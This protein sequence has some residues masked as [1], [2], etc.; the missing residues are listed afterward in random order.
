MASH[1]SI[2]ALEIP[3]TEKPG[4]LQSLGLQRARH[5]WATEHAKCNVT[6]CK[7]LFLCLYWQSVVSVFTVLE[8]LTYYFFKY[9]FS[10]TQNFFIRLQ[11]FHLLWFCVLGTI[12]QIFAKLTSSNCYALSI[13]FI[14]LKSS[15]PAILSQISFFSITFLPYYFLHSINYLYISHTHLFIYHPYFP[16]I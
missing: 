13:N 9:S 8:T 1:V 2:L 11:N 10:D 14:I 4:R 5:N 12:S 3:W 6:K 7:I 16:K 15:S